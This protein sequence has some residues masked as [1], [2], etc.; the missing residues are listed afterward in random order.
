M[1]PHN[2]PKTFQD[3]GRDVLQSFGV[4][5]PGFPHFLFKFTIKLSIFSNIRFLGIYQNTPENPDLCPREF[6]KKKKKNFR[7]KPKIG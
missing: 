7:K 1:D 2:V 4:V 5:A 6:F 3:T